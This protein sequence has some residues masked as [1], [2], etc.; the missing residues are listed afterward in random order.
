MFELRESKTS[1]QWAGVPFPPPGGGWAFINGSLHQNVLIIR[2]C[3]LSISNGLV[4][5]V[6]RRFFFLFRMKDADC[7]T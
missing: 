4:I 1:S 6:G 2:K 7:F 3:S 5:Y